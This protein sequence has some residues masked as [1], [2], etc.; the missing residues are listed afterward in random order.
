MK[1]GIGVEKIDY[2]KDLKEL[3]LPSAKQ[4][5]LVEVPE[6]NFVMIDGEGDPNTAPQFQ[7][8]MQ[9]L[10]TISYTA[11]FMLKKEGIGPIMPWPRLK[12]CGGLMIR[13]ISMRRTRNHG[14]GL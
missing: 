5:A 11:K 12:D 7:D 2:K 14:S 10:Y 9:A 3:Y 1:G 6:M 13:G 8:A 4:V